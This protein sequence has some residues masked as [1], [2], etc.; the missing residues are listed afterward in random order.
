M[1]RRRRALGIGLTAALLAIALVYALRP[2]TKAVLPG[3]S[4]ECRAAVL[5]APGHG[6][7]Q[8]ALWAVT[9]GTDQMGFTLVSGEDVKYVRLGS[10]DLGDFTGHRYLPDAVCA[11]RARERLAAAA[12]CLLAAGGVLFLMLRRRVV[13]VPT[14]G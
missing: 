6:D 13:G 7:D 14:A 8:L 2:F 9:V 5:S 4:G 3:A 10:A 12:I 11:T 1:S